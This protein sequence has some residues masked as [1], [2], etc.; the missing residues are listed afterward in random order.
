MKP[1]ARPKVT[2]RLVALALACAI[3]PR[4]LAGPYVT[5]ASGVRWNDVGGVRWND[6]G[7]VRWNDVGGVRWNDVG[8]VRWNDV[9]GV[10][11]SDA[12][13]VRW[14][15]VGGVRWNDVG[16][17]EFTDAAATGV[18]SLD[19]ELLSR[20]SF[21]PDSSS[22]SVI[23]SYH[24][25]PGPAQ[26]AEL[27][28]LGVV[29]GTRFD[30][31]PMIAINATKQQIAA[32]AALPS[33]R[34]VWADRTLS[35]FDVESRALIGADEA[36]LDPDLR[37]SGG[38]P[39]TG[40]GVTIA[41]IDS[42][43]DATHPDLPLGAKVVQ[44]VRVNPGVW[45]GPGFVAPSFVE[46]LSN[47]DLVLGHGTFVASVAA[48]TGQASA[49]LYR[50]LA[51]G[52]KLLGI[53]AGDLY[54]IHVLE[55]F[56]YVLAHA[57]Q[58]GIRVVNCS[59]GTLG[60]FDPDDP[61]N[62]AT[63]ALYDAGIAAVFA[64]GNHGPAPDTLNP[65]SVAPWVFGVGSVR[66]D[67]GLS[68]FSSR[69]IFEEL[70]YHPLL[71]APGEGII[72]A[73]P[74]GITA[75]GGT[76]GV[77]DSTSGTVVPPEYLSR[78]TVSSGTSFAAPQ[79]AAAIALLLE[80]NPGRSL[81][82]IRRSLQATATPILTQDRAESGAGRLDVWA[83][84]THGLDPARPFG[85]HVPLWLDL[86]PFR[87]E[88][89]PAVTVE[90][91]LE[92]GA[93]LPLA[94]TLPA[95]AVSFRASIAWGTLPGATDLD[96]RLL[97]PTGLEL[98][99]SDAYNSPSL[100]GRVDGVRLLG[101]TPPGGTLE[102]SWKSGLTD[103][104][105]AV[106]EEVSTAVTDYADVAALAPPDAAIVAVAVGRRVMIGRGALFAP[107]SNLERGELARALALGAGV[108]QRVPAVASFPDVH[109]N[110]PVFP[111]VES[112]AGARASRVLIDGGNGSSFGPSGSVDRLDFAVSLVRAA[113][114]EA[115][116]IAR[117]G[118]PLAV[119][120]ASQIPS[121]HRGYVA[122][123]LE[124]GFIDTIPVTGGV[125]FEPDDPVGRLDASRFLLA[126]LTDLE[127]RPRTCTTCAPGGGN[128]PKTTR[129]KR[130]G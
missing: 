58:H 99:R 70:L 128:R 122:V 112:V 83:A 117:A 77:A 125:R 53:S 81:A 52:A 89:Q 121:A 21:L 19:L 93:R 30:R 65:Y 17:L 49:G 116:A 50:G 25:A 14:N 126:L 11:W 13:G 23:V 15:D 86:R 48:G 87:I 115:E 72:G 78:Y 71:V 4:A 123:A 74:S 57:T 100:F 76:I 124:R 120:D 102:V 32:I 118:E 8:G 88:H 97:D 68:T 98:S 80:E 35:F 56:D 36:A 44:N 26:I 94:L 96:A 47:T 101:P 129:P 61:V 103:Q 69:G 90:Q 6:V 18:A 54:I 67:G 31:L 92:T 84:L 75:V 16:A 43:I 62:I 10:L 85:T 111:Y 119:E 109:G 38:A 51:P 41:V 130:A 33:V 2:T 5:E 12:A 107:S 42:G 7:G 1:L 95:A 79:V 66:K 113:G 46:G 34:S 3:G 104:P 108:P 40:A 45:P 24:V 64:A 29:G 37:T 28:A 114:R 127:G 105:F 20:F 60:F 9:G 27:V 106:R 110:D 82:D 91:V 73:K 63:R 55:A 59:W 39:F 22:I